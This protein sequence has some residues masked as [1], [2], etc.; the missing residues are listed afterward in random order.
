VID[1]H[2]GLPGTAEQTLERY[3][4][5]I[6]QATLDPFPA[7]SEQ[8]RKVMTSLSEVACAHYRKVVYQ[9]PEFIGWSSL[10]GNS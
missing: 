8:C 3:S 7:P 1:S 4:T 2:F 9:T 6:L 5:A 10:I